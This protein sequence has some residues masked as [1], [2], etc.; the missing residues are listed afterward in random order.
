MIS[1]GTIWTGAD[2]GVIDHGVLVLRKGK[3]SR[4]GEANRPTP[5]APGIETIDATGKYVTPGLIDAWTMLGIDPG[6][7]IGAAASQNAAD[8]LDVFATDVF[9]DARSAGVTSLCVEP[10]AG[11]GVV[12][13]AIVVRLADLNDLRST[14][15]ESTS[16]VARLGLG[17][18]GPISRL[19][20][21]KGLH[22]AFEQ[23]AA[24][25]ESW[26]DYREKLEE[27]EKKLK[28]GETV[29]LK[30]DEEKKEEKAAP[31]RRG[32]APRGRG[33]RRGPRPRPSNFASM[34]DSEILAW[35]ADT[36]VPGED[37][38]EDE[39][40]SEDETPTAPD[41]KKPEKGDGDKKDGDKKDKKEGDELSK[42]E[43]PAYDADQEIIVRALKRELPVR[44]EAH[45]P[46]DIAFALKIIDEFHLD[47]TIIGATGAYR[48]AERVAEAGVPVVFGQ[49]TGAGGFDRSH[50]ADFDAQAPAALAADGVSTI[51][52]GSGRKG[53]NAGS[54]YLT[55]NAA[56]AV[57]RGL[58]E[59]AAM[60][61]ITIDAAKVCGVADTLGS[62]EK[63]KLADV[64]IWSG[65]P[66]AP[67]SVVERVYVG[68]V[69]VYRRAGN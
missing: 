51:V 5:P 10:P 36:H 64:V 7:S 43:R 9:S 1:G 34:S 52:I 11:S 38:L 21:I 61:A 66:L 48:A 56:I 55:Q 62:L 39:K 23:A 24:Y 12:G 44:F 65:H 27:Y 33:R 40:H 37:P 31:R 46:G 50:T 4:V 16:L 28:D 54:Q 49:L 45:R 30:K 58:D 68:G 59:D 19:G 60:R 8:A 18:R 41:Q 42:P 17:V 6:G 63:G 20:E 69:E 25:R 22:D 47:A 3:I 15:T 67:D 29:K 14:T 53:G 26:D 2:S 32:P 57:G 13:T 35:L